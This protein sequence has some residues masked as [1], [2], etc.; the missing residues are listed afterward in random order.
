[1]PEEVKMD[2][3]ELLQFLSNRGGRYEYA[4]VHCKFGHVVFEQEIHKT[5]LRGML[6]FFDRNTE[7]IVTDEDSLSVRV[8][9]DFDEKDFY[10]GE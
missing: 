2:Q 1:M 4:Y 8:D 5:T 6:A 7:F 10:Y 3:R 9:E